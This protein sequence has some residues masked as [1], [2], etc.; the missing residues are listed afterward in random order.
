M[1]IMMIPEAKSS[2]YN[3]NLFT[4]WVMPSYSSMIFFCVSTFT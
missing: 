3:K 1:I 4:R 2:S